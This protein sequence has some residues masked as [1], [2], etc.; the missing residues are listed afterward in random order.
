M[1]RDKFKDTQYFMNTTSFILEN[2]DK[3]KKK[4]SRELNLRPIVFY[5]LANGLYSYIQ[6]AYSLGI[7]VKDLLSPSKEMLHNYALS[8][9]MNEDYSDGGESIYNEDL[10]A[11]SIC[12]LLNTN[13]ELKIYMDIL[14][15]VN[16][17]DYL[18]DFLFNYVQRHN[19]PI[20]SPLI[21]DSYPSYQFLKK[22]TQSKKSVAEVMMKEYLDNY[23]YTKKNLSRRYNTHKK[24]DN[25]YDGYWSFEAAAITKV[26]NLDDSRYIN[27]P[28]YPKD[29]LHGDPAD[30]SFGSHII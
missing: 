13:E 12:I 6:R 29:M 24:M 27:S 5:G 19:S 8:I 11:V 28:Y 2:I 25:S 10:A 30:Y 16:Y 1:L 23:Y 7:P 3:E 18:L 15:K 20:N 14:H 26:M 9:Q 4:I 21:F 22:I 17:R